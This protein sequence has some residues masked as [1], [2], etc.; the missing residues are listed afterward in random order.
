MIQFKFHTAEEAQGESKDLLLGIKN[1]FGFIPNMFAYMAE[2]PTTIHA[3]LQLNELVSK[4]S[5]TVSEQQV[6]LLA[7]SVENECGFCVVAHRAIGKMKNANV[8]SLTAIAENTEIVDSKERALATFVRTVV[9]TKGKP[10]DLD[11]EQ[12]LNAGFTK[13]QVFESMLIVSIKTLSNYINFLVK[14]EPNKELL[15]LLKA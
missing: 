2:A 8:Q 15:G 13:Q 3:Y 14:S 6:A 5:F 10:T 7:V 1:Q 9:K 12:F 11:V 4:T